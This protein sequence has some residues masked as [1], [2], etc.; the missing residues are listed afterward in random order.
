MGLMK[1]FAKV[2]NVDA[3]AA[4]AWAAAGGQVVDRPF[5][6]VVAALRNALQAEASVGLLL[7]ATS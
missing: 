2:P 4:S 7:P 5:S 3:A 6:D 1:M